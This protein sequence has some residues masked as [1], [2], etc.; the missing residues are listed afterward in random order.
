M[1]KSKFKKVCGYTYGEFHFEI[2]YN[3]HKKYAKYQFWYNSS[4][5]A[6]F[7]TEEKARMYADAFEQGLTAYFQI[8]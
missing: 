3:P 1:D 5:L 6:N 2:I 7:D 8:I 4:N